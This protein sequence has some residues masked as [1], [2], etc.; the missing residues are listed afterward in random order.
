MINIDRLNKVL[1]DNLGEIG[2]SANWGL[3]LEGTTVATRL[4]TGGDPT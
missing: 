3:T 2:E 1:N 4:A